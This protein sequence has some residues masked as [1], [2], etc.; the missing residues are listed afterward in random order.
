MAH[1]IVIGVGAIGS[2]LVPHLARS[3]RVS[4]VTL[5]DRD[6]YETANLGG[7]QIDVRHVGQPKAVVQ[8]RRLRHIRPDLGVVAVSDAVEDLPLG[9]LRAAVIL[10]CLDSRR[11]RMVVNQAAWRL[12]VPW[13]DAGIDGGGLLA[14]VQ[15]FVPGPDA[16]C[17]ECAWDQADYDA[18][19]QTYPCA[20][21]RS[22]GATGAPSTIGALA[23]ALQ[24]IECDKI[25][26][27]DTARALV[28]RDVLIDAR[29]HTHFVTAHRRNPSCRMPDHQGWQIDGLGGSPAQT[30]LADILGLGSTLRGAAASL[31]IGVAG[32]RIATELCCDAC[33][34][35]RATFELDRRARATWPR[36][37]RCGG[38][39]HAVGFGLHD[40]APADAVPS[41]A[42]DRPLSALGVRT[43]DVLTL[44]TSE[45]DV[46]VELGE[47]A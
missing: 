26:G 29:H 46:H 39:V 41:D 34:E 36:C 19:E 18:L 4:R 30:T 35:S 23:A 9:A 33:G 21:D 20:P 1:V 7:Q 5:I 6:H 16:P 12:G 24:A 43:R 31:S 17:L 2:H 3:P 8:A 45:L 28:G 42:L 14:R 11:A 27:G 37:P 13:I 44:R 32:Q 25:L 38:D 10:A 15:V 22:S 47:P 40:L